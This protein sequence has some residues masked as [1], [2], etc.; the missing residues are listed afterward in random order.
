MGAER[1]CGF[2]VVVADEAH[3]M[4]NWTS[5]RAKVLIPVM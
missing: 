3:Y 5:K 1:L 4:K 2:K